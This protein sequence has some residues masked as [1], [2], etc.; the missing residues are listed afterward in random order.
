MALPI[1][2]AAIPSLLRPGLMAAF[3]DYDVYPEQ[4]MDIFS[5]HKSDKQVEYEV[6][7]KLLP[8]AFL[9]PEGQSITY[10]GMNQMYQTTYKNVT[11]GIGY[12]ITREAVVDNLYKD[13]FPMGAIALRDSLS[14]YKNIQGA[15]VLNNAFSS[16]YAGADGVALCSTAHPIVGGTYSNTFTI[17]TALNETSIEDALTTVQQFLSASGLRVV[18]KIKKLVVPAN[19]QWT[20]NRLTESKFR[21]STANND[22]S[23][24][25]NTK[26]IAEGYV[27]NQFLTN[28]LNWFITTDEPNGFKYYEREPVITDIMTDPDTNNLKVRAFERYCFNWSNS[29]CVFG[30]QGV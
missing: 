24:I 26:A 21:T 7:M 3:S 12:I 30:S 27:T 4:W 22:I 8:T 29:R 10:A 17:P 18:K 5:K 23:A 1:N 2:T 20:A 15:N 6:E 14:Q 16:T 9:K 28:S 19:L 11:I 13:Q 25:Y